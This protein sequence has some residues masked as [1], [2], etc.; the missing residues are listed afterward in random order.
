METNFKIKYWAMYLGIKIEKKLSLLYYVFYLWRRLLVC[1]AIVFLAP[2]PVF[3]VI[4]FLATSVAMA[5]YSFKS[6]PFHDKHQNW[7][8]IFNEVC[9]TSLSYVT[10]CFTDY[11][12][13]AKTKYELGWWA[14]IIFAINFG[15]N[16]LYIILR[17]LYMCCRRCRNK[18]VA[19]RERNKAI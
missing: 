19:K 11:V 17:T 12:L 6:H 1:A 2:W 9:I 4:L 14:I 10:L 16:V 5:A 8:D 3:Q 13:S 7:L 15:V 18:M